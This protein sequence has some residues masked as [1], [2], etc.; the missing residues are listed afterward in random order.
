MPELFTVEE[1]NLM[2]IFDMSSR[3][4]LIV[5]LID[6]TADFEDAEMLDIAVAVLDKLSKMSDEDFD[7]LELNPIYEDCD[8]QEV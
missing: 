7:A 4:T 1:V 8:E 2:C 5:E 6:A 3:G